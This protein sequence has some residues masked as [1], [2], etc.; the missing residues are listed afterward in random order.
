MMREALDSVEL[1]QAR[2]VADVDR[3]IQTNSSRQKNNQG[4]DC[5]IELGLDM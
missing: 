3:I 4:G 1:S 5:T 2:V